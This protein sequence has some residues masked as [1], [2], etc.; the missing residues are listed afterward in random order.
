MICIV[1][2][3]T[4]EIFN[5]T[6]MSD[7]REYP[8]DVGDEGEPASSPI[9]SMFWCHCHESETATVRVMSSPIHYGQQRSHHSLSFNLF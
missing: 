6:G 5:C 7:S 2:G 3:R 1:I 4:K 9:A 8:T